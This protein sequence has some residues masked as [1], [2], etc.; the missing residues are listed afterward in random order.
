MG[1]LFYTDENVFC[2]KEEYFFSEEWLGEKMDEKR[3]IMDLMMF[4]QSD[5]F[6]T[7]KELHANKKAKIYRHEVYADV[8]FF[9]KRWQWKPADVLAFFDELVKKEDVAQRM[10]GD[11]RIISLKDFCK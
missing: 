10:V 9:A 1:I 7:L 4:A 5:S 6:L 11:E 8:D 3:A 2:I